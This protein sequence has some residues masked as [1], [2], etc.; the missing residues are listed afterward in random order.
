MILLARDCKF[1]IFSFVLN[2][3]V[4][5]IHIYDLECSCRFNLSSFSCCSITLKY[6][7]LQY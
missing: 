7:Q 3:F 6:R 2:L 1:K 4:P 5:R